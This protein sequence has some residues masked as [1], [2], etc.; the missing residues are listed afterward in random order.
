MIRQGEPGD[1]FY[2]VEAGQF[3]V[4]LQHPGSVQPELVHTYL[5]QVCA[6]KYSWV[7][8]CS[9]QNESETSSFFCIRERL[10]VLYR[11]SVQHCFPVHIF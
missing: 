6:Y 3:D 2:I 8:E 7:T 10:D 9:I 11:M 4:Y 1:H 5:S